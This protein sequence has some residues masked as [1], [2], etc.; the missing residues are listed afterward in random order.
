MTRRLV[1]SFSLAEA[2]RHQWCDD[3]IGLTG[4]WRQPGPVY[5]IS[6]RSLCGVRNANLFAA[7]RCISADTTV[8]DVTR[9]IPL[10]VVTGEAAG[11]A[12]ALAVK[13]TDANVQTLDLG[14]LQRQ[15]R[16]QGVMLDPALVRP[17]A[18]EKAMEPAVPAGSE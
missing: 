2:H 17:A 11:T 6:L 5:A 18:S 9:A 1:G 14:L 10:C 15:L 7:G 16:L 12:A 4:D 3:A 13:R 8:W